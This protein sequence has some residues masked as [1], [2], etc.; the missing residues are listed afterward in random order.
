[1]L[2]LDMSA[3]VVANATALTA[4]GNPLD[5]HMVRSIMLSQTLHYKKK[6]KQYGK[7]IMCFDSQD[8]W[9]KDIFPYYKMN[10]K[11]ARSKSKFDWK[12]FA[13]LYDQVK[14]EF[15]EYVPYI[16]MEV[17]KCEADDTIAVLASNARK[18]VMII[19]GDK[20]LVQLQHKG[21]HIK[22]W[23][24]STKKLLTLN[25]KDYC[26][27]EHIIRGDASD[28]IPNILSDEDTF[29]CDHKKQKSVMATFVKDAQSMRVPHNIC[30][31]AESLD[32]WKMNVSLIDLNEI[33]AEYVKAI[34]TEYMHQF[35]NGTKDSLVAYFKKYNL[36]LMYNKLAEFRA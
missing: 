32:R 17:D 25:N 14:L 16:H 35:Q 26:L 27:V 31:T 22:Q 5:E 18:P 23:S 10:R 3:I 24:T 29:M 36:R 34:K 6:F 20:D 15:I 11:K 8:Y 13:N 28:G 30:P 4:Q 2:L 12:E 7:P 1:M 9:R 21:K 19:S 33:P